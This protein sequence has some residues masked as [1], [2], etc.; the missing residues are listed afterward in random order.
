MTFSPTFGRL[1][2]PTFQPNSIKKAD[3]SWWLSGGIAAANCVA[4]YQPK[5]AASYAASLVNLTGNA[6]Y[7]ATGY[8][9]P[10]WD[11][12]YGWNLIGYSP[13]KYIRTG[14][15]SMTT[16]WSI[17]AL[18]DTSVAASVFGVS[19]AAG[20]QKRVALNFNGGR[21]SWYLD[22]GLYGTGTSSI[23]AGNVAILGNKGYVNGTLDCTGTDT[24]DYSGVD[25]QIGGYNKN[26]TAD[27]FATGAQIKIKAIAIY[28]TVISTAQ[29]SALVTAMAAL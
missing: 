20:K 25:F 12:S 6:T 22:S 24:G 7:D 23:K 9:T 18:V 26:G 19:N 13:F 21:A 8:N 28:N 17:V 4:A 16:G 27:G 3:T 14:I 29:L 11:A 1:F 10:T 15:T 5:G 2:S